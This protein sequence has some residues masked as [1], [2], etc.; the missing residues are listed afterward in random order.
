MV[1]LDRTDAGAT[2]DTIARGVVGH[3]EGSIP[4]RLATGN[5]TYSLNAYDN[6]KDTPAVQGTVR[7]VKE[8]SKHVSFR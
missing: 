6:T 2:G 8:G 7:Y 1:D 4:Y 5:I 3:D